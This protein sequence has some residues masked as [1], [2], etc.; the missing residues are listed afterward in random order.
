[1]VYVRREWYRLSTEYNIIQ[2]VINGVKPI[3][4]AISDREK[5]KDEFIKL[6]TDAGLPHIVAPSE[7]FRPDLPE[8]YDINLCQHG[9]VGELFDLDDV[10]ESY[11]LLLELDPDADYYHNLKKQILKLRNRQLSDYLTDWDYANPKTDIDL[12]LTGLLLGYPLE[13]T[14]ALIMGT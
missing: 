8:R 1:M 11:Q 2:A 3:G 5:T 9:K 4:F 7:S 14:S 10:I 13:S 12:I 6:I